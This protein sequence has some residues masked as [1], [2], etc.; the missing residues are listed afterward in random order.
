MA[1]SSSSALA[2]LMASASSLSFR[3]ILAQGTLSG[4]WGRPGG[5]VLGSPEVVGGGGRVPAGGP[6]LTK[7]PSAMP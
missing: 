2:F 5:A 3:S 7:S 1:F 6:Y 4:R